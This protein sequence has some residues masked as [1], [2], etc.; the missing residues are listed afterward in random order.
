MEMVHYT[1]ASAAEHHKDSDD[2]KDPAGIWS[3]RLVMSTGFVFVGLILS[4]FTLY[5]LYNYLY[6]AWQ[7]VT[8]PS[9]KE[10]LSDSSN[11]LLIPISHTLTTDIP[12]LSANTY[13]PQAQPYIQDMADAT[14]KVEVGSLSVK[15]YVKLM[16]TDMSKCLV[17]LSGTY[18]GS[19]LA[20]K[21]QLISG[22]LPSLS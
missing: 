10:G 5:L 4:L 11:V 19:V 21:F 12:A 15:D 17:D 1:T 20:P 8:A 16:K 18:L 14:N 7:R 3:F 9:V 22:V 2:D 6:E 13:Y